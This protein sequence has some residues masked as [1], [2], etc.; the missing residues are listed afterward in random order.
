[1]RS[2]S[3]EAGVGFHYIFMRRDTIKPTTPSNHNALWQ[4]PLSNR[5]Q[6]VEIQTKESSCQAGESREA[7]WRRW[8]F[9]PTLIGFGYAAVEKE[10]HSGWRVVV[11]ESREREQQG[12]NYV[13]VI[14]S[15]WE[16]LSL[17]L[18]PAPHIL[19]YADSLWLRPFLHLGLGSGGV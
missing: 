11:S 1:M 8:P 18:L 14:T 10:R 13:P 5:G 9:S 6:D 3:Q 2:H 19:C 17:T 15:I 12:G 4:L 7:C 16:V